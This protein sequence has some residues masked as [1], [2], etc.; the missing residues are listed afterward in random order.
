[1]DF[2]AVR[3]NSM[4]LVFTFSKKSKKKFR[5]MDVITKPFKKGFS[6][7]DCC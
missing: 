1:M 4:I 7:I 5:M 3:N 2:Q 6:P